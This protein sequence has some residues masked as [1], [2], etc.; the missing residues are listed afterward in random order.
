MNNYISAVT[1]LTD[2]EISW[3]Y[4]TTKMDYMS[5]NICD[6]AEKKCVKIPDFKCWWFKF[7]LNNLVINIIT[8]NG[9]P[10]ETTRNP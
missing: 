4:I 2:S 8:L 7:K 6:W 1:G 5:S 9:I 3:Y 10:K